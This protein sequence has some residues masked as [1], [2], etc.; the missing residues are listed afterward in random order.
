MITYT[1]TLFECS[2][3]IKARPAWMR[4]LIYR[5]LPQYKAMI[6]AEKTA[7]RL[8]T[9]VIK[10]RR[11]SMNDPHYVEP[12]DMTQWMMAGRVKHKFHDEDYHYMAKAQLQLSVAA[13]HTTSMALTNMC[14]DLVANPEYQDI[15]RDEVKEALACNN[16]S[17]EGPIMHKLPKT[18]SI[19]KESQRHEPVG[20]T[21]M[22]RWVKQP[23]TLKDGTYL[24]AGINVTSNSY[25]ITHDD[26]V[27][28]SGSDP[29]KFDG[30]RYYNMRNKLTKMGS[31]TSEVGGKHQF[32]S[33]SSGSLMFGT[34]PTPLS[35]SLS[36]ILIFI[37]FL[38]SL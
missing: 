27:L 13:I 38:K 12:L 14:W 5:T 34:F 15:I 37:L 4:P 16:Q 32:V 31:E 2:Q 19:M 10:A 22:D 3:A 28:Q 17:W 18:D 1:S 6:A 24:P 11:E 35:L 29:N 20:L 7:L 8:I 25:A 21:V 9:P 23:F 33:V 26:D 36:L 30:L